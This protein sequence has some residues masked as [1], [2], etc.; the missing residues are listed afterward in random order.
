MVAY[1]FQK[2]FVPPVLA[3]L[4]PGPWMPGMKR[5]TL[6]LPRSSGHAGPGGRVDLYTAMRTKH[7]RL[8][9]RAP[10]I[11]RMPIAVSF[12]GDDFNI[13]RRA[14]EALIDG[15]RGWALFELIHAFALSEPGTYLSE[16]AAESFARADGFEDLA[17]M[18][19]FFAADRPD[20]DCQLDMV[21]VAWAPP[22]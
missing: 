14:G 7:C 6:R 1:S 20:G 4:E 13:W 8:L 21:L 10:A 11:L 3:G 22:A 12:Q 15:A 2:R 5:H 19:D 9:G 18:R 16:R 17:A